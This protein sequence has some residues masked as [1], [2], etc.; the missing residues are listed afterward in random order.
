MSNLCVYDPLATYITPYRKDA[1]NCVLT[2]TFNLLCLILYMTLWQ[3]IT[4]Y[5]KDAMNCV[6]TK[7]HA[8]RG[9]LVCVHVETQFIAS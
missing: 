6:S 2:F 9:I 1:M 7:N 5:R 8:N 3:L 4:P